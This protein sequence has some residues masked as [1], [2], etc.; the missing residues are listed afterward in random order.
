MLRIY[1]LAALR[2]FR[3]HRSSFFINLI[4]L[5]SGLVCTMLIFLWVQDELRMDTFHEKDARIYR[6]MEHQ[7]YADGHVMTTTSTPGLLSQ[8]LKR[9]LPEVEYAV[10]QSWDWELLLS[11]EDLY[12]TQKGFYADEDFFRIFTFP[13]VEGDPETA[14]ADKSSIVISQSVANKLFKGVSAV[15]KIIGVDR[16]YTMKVSGV[17]EDVKSNSTQQFD[18]VM[19]FEVIRQEQA[20]LR[21]WG[22]NGPKTTVTLHEGADVSAINARITNFIKNRNEG[23]VVE[24]FMYPFSHSYLYGRFEGGVPSGGRIEYVR[25]FSLIAVFILL[26]ACINFMNLSTA[27]ASRRAK[28]VGIRKAI[29]ANR[30]ELIVQYLTESLL[31]AVLSMMLAIVILPVMLPFFNE[32]TSKSLSMAF[33]LNVILAMTA[34][35]LFTGF[36]AGSY[37]ALYL[38]SFQAA[39]VMKNDLKTSVGEIWAR[40]GLVIFQF[41]LSICLI[42]GVFVISKQ[43]DFVQGKHLGYTKENLVAIS[44][45]GKLEDNHKLFL[46][47]L[48]S[49]PL[50]TS[51]AVSGHR[52]NGRNNNTSGVGWEGKHP[53]EK[54]LFE[55][56]RCNEDFIPTMEIKMIEGRNFSREYSTD[57]SAV[58]INEAAARV[59]GM[60]NPVGQKLDIW[61]SDVTIIGLAQDFNYSSL[62]AKV[63]PAIFYLSDDV[64]VCYAR[65]QAGKTMEALDQ[66]EE[67]HQE[68]NPGFTFDY[69][70]Q[71]VE[72]AK[73]YKA[74]QQVASLSQYFAGLA[75][76]ISCLGLF[77]LAAFTAERRLKE[78]GIRKVLGAS[79][80]NLMLLITRDFTR[81]VLIS[82]VVALPLSY[83]TMSSWLARFEYRIELH[84][85]FFVVAGAVALLIAWFTVGSQAFRAANVNPASCLKDE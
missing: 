26:I 61:D 66:I 10:T 70:F 16:K 83:L 37:P 63:E 21:N 77:G 2:N 72:Y 58:V 15:G 67:I 51:A 4:G 62:H 69:R 36:V 78:I 5:S 80:G 59:M 48:Q 68:L 22:S 14:L 1:L 39:R 35:V 34:I 79:V 45:A 82:I 12:F 7:R 29:G 20:W 50:V 25:L 17:F 44:L 49:N 54:V 33:S 3:K 38:S 6:V 75:I 65:L 41:I 73:M 55:M 42:V 81:L 71:D 8:E 60:T 74:E 9:E 40:K 13:F 84:W 32:V 85:W 64:W 31:L 11:Y 53:D 18:F 47:K 57:S 27:K 24:L 19:P 52:F 23:S 46:E 56:I 76:L 28:E 30:R 43:I